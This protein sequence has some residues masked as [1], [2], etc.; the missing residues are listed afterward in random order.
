M[1][2]H[3][4]FVATVVVLGAL[5]AI[6]GRVVGSLASGAFAAAVAAV[7]LCVAYYW[8]RKIYPDEKRAI[9]GLVEFLALIFVGAL[10]LYVVDA[11]Q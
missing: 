7:A 1:E 8:Y 5:G 3:L 9:I 4:R 10:V 2:K 6:F 11:M